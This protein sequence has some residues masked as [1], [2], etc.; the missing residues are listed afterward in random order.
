MR[1]VMLD[2][3]QQVALKMAD[4][5]RIQAAHE[6]VSFK[7]HIAD[8]DE[9]VRQLGDVEVLCIMRERTPVMRSL[10]EK[11]PKLRLIVTTGGAHASL[12]VKAA[13]ERGITVCGTGSSRFA[14]AEL[15]FGILLALARGIVAQHN[16]VQSGGWQLELG[17]DVRGKTL[18]LIGLGNLGSQ[19]AGFGKAFG[20][21]PIAWSQNL[22][23]E[24]AKAGG[25]ARV[26]KDELF[27][28]SDFI[29]VHYKLS[30]RSRG[31]VG[32]A[33]IAMMKPTA[34]LINT[35]RGPLIDEKAMID[36][37]EA[38]RIAGAGLDVFDEEPLPADHYFR[39]SKRVV[40]TPHVGYASADNYVTYFRELVEDIEAWLAGTPVRVLKG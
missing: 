7:D 34:Y 6:V 13:T 32:A 8:E 11:L 22:T 2:D 23:D 16:S 30:A 31:I 10:I 14:T 29:S 19:V 35:S 3:Y 1:I 40:V 20:M 24:Q 33:E 38:G 15:T 36:A 9:L 5:S 4:W 25:A 21:V 39:T 37:I 26:T 12:D 28:Q 17:Q 27:R 18:G